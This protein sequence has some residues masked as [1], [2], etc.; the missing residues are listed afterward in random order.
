MQNA[1]VESFNSRPRDEFLNQT[2]FTSLMQARLALQDPRRDYKMCGLTRGSAGWRLRP[3]SQISHR[4]RAKAPRSRMAPRLGPLHQLCKMA[5][6]RLLVPLDHSR[7]QRQ[8]TTRQSEQ[9]LR[10]PPSVLI[11]GA[12]S[13]RSHQSSCI[14]TS[15]FAMEFLS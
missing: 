10:Y 1:F 2:L 15:A 12:F 8:L 9:S 6:A 14:R 3:I 5:T 4:N 11:S 7:W 13:R